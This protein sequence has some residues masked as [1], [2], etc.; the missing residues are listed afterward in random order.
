MS[1]VDSEML[2]ELMEESG[3]TELKLLV[4]SLYAENERSRHVYERLGFKETGHIKA[5]HLRDEYS[6]EVTIALEL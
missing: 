3:K 4:L 1:R 6:D 2:R 5:Y